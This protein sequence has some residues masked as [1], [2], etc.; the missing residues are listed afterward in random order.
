MN[1]LLCFLCC[2]VTA[3][4]VSLF[5]NPFAAAPKKPQEVASLEDQRAAD[6]R[7]DERRAADRQADRRAYERKMDN[8][9][10]DRQL[11]NAKWDANRQNRIS[12]ENAQR[13]NNRR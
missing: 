9:R 2:C 10:D 13:D 8:L 3:Y 11:D 5:W 1:R 4:A 12:E 7:A 6:R